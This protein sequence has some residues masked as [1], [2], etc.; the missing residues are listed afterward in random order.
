MCSNYAANTSVK[1]LSGASESAWRSRGWGR[2]ATGR[3]WEATAAPGLPLW[4][5]L[6]PP[7][8]RD[9]PTKMRGRRLGGKQMPL[10]VSATQPLSGK[11]TVLGSPHPGPWPPPPSSAPAGV[12]GRCGTGAA[13][14]A[15]CRA[16]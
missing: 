14:E 5:P 16:E 9:R 6:S 4:A 15:G 11:V 7:P 10:T 12:G 8:P 3:N 13:R 1:V 2:G